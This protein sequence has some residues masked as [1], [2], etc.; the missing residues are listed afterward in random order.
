MVEQPTDEQLRQSANEKAVLLYNKFYKIIRF[1]RSS[2]QSAIE[3]AR[4]CLEVNKNIF[5][6]T[7]KGKKFDDTVGCKFWNYVIEE[8]INLCY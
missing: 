6:S 4:E 8:L 3:C 1:S 7:F 5:E 2:K